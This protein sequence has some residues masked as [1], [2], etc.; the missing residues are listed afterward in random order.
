ME[1][2]PRFPTVSTSSSA[3][4]CWRS[5]ETL[6]AQAPEGAHR[7]SVRARAEGG[8][9]RE[10]RPERARAGRAGRRAPPDAADIRVGRH[11]WPRQREPACRPR[12]RR[13]TA[14]TASPPDEV[15][16]AAG[17]RSVRRAL[18]SEGRRAARAA[19]PERAARGGS[20]AGLA[21]ASSSSTAA[22]CRSSWSAAAIVSLA[23]KE[24]STGV[25]L[26][27]ITVLNA[28]VGLRQEGKAAERDERAP[29]DGEGDRAGTPRR[30][31][32]R[33]PGRGGGRRRRRRCW[34]PATTC[35]PTGGSSRRARLQIDESA[36]TGESVPASKGVEVPDG[37]D[38]APGEQTDMAFMHTPVTHGSA[39]DDRH[40]DGR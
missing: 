13:R 6:E 9:G 26:I 27:L 2:D 12:R 33:D 14:G 4:R 19:W 20:G 5:S 28:V 3:R 30:V 11:R 40:R 25:L 16:S 22:T 34:R 23:I 31:R 21:A 18:Q 7:R 29:G 1:I 24:W 36:L 15:G 17:R 32:G 38:L 39:R 8:D 35:R 10:R 37:D